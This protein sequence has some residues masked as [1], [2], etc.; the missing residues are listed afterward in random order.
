MPPWDPHH[1]PCAGG[2]AG[3][4]P[5]CRPRYLTGSGTNSVDVLLKALKDGGGNRIL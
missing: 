3:S 2:R 5:T 1:T 4:S